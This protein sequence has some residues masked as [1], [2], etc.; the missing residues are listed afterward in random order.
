M[1]TLTRGEGGQESLTVRGIFMWGP[2][3]SKMETLVS[4]GYP[5]SSTSPG[6]STQ[7]VGGTAWTPWDSCEGDGQVMDG[8]TT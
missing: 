2:H 4:S 7:L 5:V 3:R 1:A 8:H 6:K